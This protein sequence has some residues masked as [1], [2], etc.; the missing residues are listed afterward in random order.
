MVHH[1]K[2]P[3]FYLKS[4]PWGQ[5]HTKCSQVPCTLYDLCLAKFEDATGNSLGEDV[6]IRSKLFYLD[7]RVKVTQNFPSTLYIMRPMSLQ[8]YYVQQLRRRCIYS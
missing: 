6:F 2:C 5:G 1:R 4:L 3:L 8:S 7:K